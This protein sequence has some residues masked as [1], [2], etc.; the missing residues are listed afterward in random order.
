LI[1]MHYGALPVVHRVGGLADTVHP[2]DACLDAADTGCGILFDAE[3]EEAFLAAYENALDIYADQERFRKAAAHNM[4]TD[5]SW[6]R[7]AAAYKA[8]Y[9]SVSEG[10][11]EC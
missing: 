11:I 5:V 7:S 8:L 1:A 3:S 4:N 10:R 9:L 2:I 6:T